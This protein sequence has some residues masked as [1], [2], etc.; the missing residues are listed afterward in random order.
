MSGALERLKRP[1]MN[2][3][4]S[5]LG[6]IDLTGVDDSGQLQTIQA[7]GMADEVVEG[8][9]HLQAYGFAA[10]PFVEA[11]GLAVFPGGTRSHGI[12]IAVADR[13]Y[14]LKNLQEGEVAIYDDQGQKILLGR[15]GIHVFSDKPIMIEGEEVTVV[16]NKVVVESDDIQLGGP[17]GATVA[18]VGDAVSGGVITG[19]GASKV[20]AV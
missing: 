17:G 16:A 19:P 2:R 7:T 11:E 12:V 10:R 5:L 4:Q 15:D 3:I 20:K 13:R 1:L 8:L 18:L 9:E 14:R 6:R